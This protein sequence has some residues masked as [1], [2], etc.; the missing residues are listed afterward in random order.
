MSGKVCFGCGAVDCNV[1]RL[2]ARY[3]AAAAALRVAAVEYA[4]TP[5]DN[6]GRLLEWAAEDFDD[7]KDAL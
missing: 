3:R 1:C 7:A 6:Y 5:D 2:S 4:H